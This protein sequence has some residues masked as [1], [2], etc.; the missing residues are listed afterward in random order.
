M[1]SSRM[2]CPEVPATLPWCFRYLDANP[3]SGLGSPCSHPRPTEQGVQGWGAPG[4]G[5]VLLGTA[6]GRGS[7]SE[8]L[9]R[10]ILLTLL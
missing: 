4:R 3:V 8:G 10:G 6:V 9:T 2:L 1:G 5:N 7:S